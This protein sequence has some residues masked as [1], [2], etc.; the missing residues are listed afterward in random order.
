MTL[1]GFMFKNY[2]FLTKWTNLTKSNL[3]HQWPLWGT[4]E[5]LKLTFLKTELDSHGSK[6]VKTEGDAYFE[7]SSVNRSLKLPL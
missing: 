6:I 5:P 1:A 7:A 4:F 3:E 2:A